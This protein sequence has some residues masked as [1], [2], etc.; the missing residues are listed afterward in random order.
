MIAAMDLKIICERSRGRETT[1]RSVCWSRLVPQLVTYGVGE[2]IIE[3]LDGAEQR[4]RR[5][6]SQALARLGSVTPV[7]YGHVDASTEAALWV[8]D[9]AAWA[10]GKGGSWADRIRPRLG[11]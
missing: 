4:D 8:A 10:L 5:D 6:I 3:R 9:A 2:L 11:S 1:A 7:R